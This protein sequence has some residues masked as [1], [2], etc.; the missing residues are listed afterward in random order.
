M[1][2]GMQRV[3]VVGVGRQEE[4]GVAS[5]S[6]A[7]W[8]AIEDAHVVPSA[9]RRVVVLLARTDEE[10][11]PD[12]D[13]IPGVSV[14]SPR[15]SDPVYAAAEACLRAD[16]PALVVV[17]DEPGGVAVALALE[18]AQAEH[19]GPLSDDA[20]E[21]AAQLR[22]LRPRDRTSAPRATSPDATGAG[23]VPLLLSGRTEAGLRAQ[24]GRLATHLQERTDISVADAAFTQ[25]TARTL[26][27]HRAMV[28]A[29]DRVGV[30][31]ALRAVA[32]GRAGD[33]A[34]RAGS[35]GPGSAV[36]V[37]PGQ[38]A[39]WVGM[40]RELAA[41]APVFRDKLAECAREL[42]PFVDF[43]LDD[44][45][46]G[47]L[48]LERV[49]VIQPALFAVMVS[50]AELWRSNGVT[51]AAVVGHSFGE[52][53]AVTA[54]GA[55]TLADG[56][57]LV[58]AV[59][60]ALARLQGNGEMVAVALPAEQV[61]ALV[62]EWDLDLDIAVVNGPGST[63]VAGTTESATT[64]LERLRARDVRA[65][66]LPIG[67]AG[68]SWRMEPAHEYLV[69][70][71]A[72]VRPRATR[73]P[74]Y[75]STTTDPLDT[76]ALDAE[77]WFLSLREPARFQQVIEELLGQGHRVFVEMSPHPVLTL[78]IEETAAHL[79]REVVV[80]DTMR[81]DDAGHDRYLRA[82]AEAHLHGVAPDWSTV[83]PDARRVSLPPYRLDLD[84]ADTAGSDGAGPGSELRERLL[85]C[86]PAQ[87]VDEAVRLVADAVS[88]QIEPSA[89][90]IGADEAFRSLGVD[91]A[92]AL[93]VRNRLVEMT[94]L[95]LPVT[96][97]FDHPTP[98]ALAEELVRALLGGDAPASAP[99]AS[100]PVDPDEP[101]AIV[102]M[103]C[104]FPGG[105]GSPDELWQLVHEGRDAVAAF[106]A[107]RGWDLTA[108][109]DADASQ[110]G[111][112][113]QREAALLDGVAE[114]DAGFFG[115][116]SREALAMDPQQR[117]LLETSW[118]ALE[119]GGID[120]AS[121][122]GS[123]T[124]VFTGVMSLPYGQPLHQAR[125]D[126]EGYVM[127]GTTSS[128]V[129]GRLSY[130]LGLEGPALTL[131]T[132]CSSSLVALHLA[133]QSLRRGESDLALVGG[134]TVM[135][136]PGL[137][138]EFSRLRA[139][140]PD[141]RSKPFSADADGF[142]MAE[143]VAVLVVE[144]LSDARRLGHDVLAVV[145]GSAVNQDGASNGLT[146]PSGPAQQRAI[147]AA[148]DSAGLRA[149]DVDVVEAHGT[150]TRLGDPIEAQALLATYGSDRPA[151]RPLYVGS[152]KSNIG[153]AQA[154]AGVAGVVKMVQALRHGV[155]P[156]SL[157]ADNPAH[158]VEWSSDT[159]E[160]LAQAREWDRADGRPRRAGV[161][162]F[163]ISGT[164]AHIILEE[165]TP[166]TPEASEGAESAAPWA[167]VAVP[168][169]LSGKTPEAVR[170]Q[171][172]ALRE[173]L[174]SHPE[175]PLVHV[176]RELATRRTAF[177]HRA[178]VTGDREEVR[179]GL[180]EVSPVLAGSG[181]VAAVF[182]GQG[183]QRA[184]M[185]RQLAA[186]FPVFDEALA[187]V[188]GHLD[189]ELGRGLREVMWS[190]DPELLGRTEFAQPALFAFEVA[191]ARLW[192]S[193]GVS[194]TAVVGHSVGE[195]AAAVVAGVLTVP[196]AARLVVARGRLMQS[197]PGGG[198]MLAV[199]AGEDEVAAT[200]GD[201]ARVAV[202]AVNGPGAVVV[203]GARDE[204][205]RVGEIWRGRGRRVTELRVSHAFHS[206]L[207]EPVLDEFRA[208]VE[209]LRFRPPTV[210]IRAT[211]DTAHPIDTPEYW[212]DHARRAVRFGDA[213]E[214]LAEADILIEVGPDA[215]LAPLI[216]TG[217]TVL[218][219]TRRGRSET[220][221][222]LTALGR[223]H[224]HGADVDWAA[225]LPPAP[226]T[227][228]PTY[229]FQRQ[230]YWD[231][232]SDAS[233]GAGAGA[234][235]RSHPMLT[236]RTDLP[237]AGGL[238]LSGRLAP[239]SDPWL[240][241]H[242]VMG[243]VLLP[244]TG[245]VELA[246]EA[247]RA[248]GAGSVDELVLRAP[249]VF[250]EGAPRDLQVWVGPDQGAERELQI[251][252]RETGGDWT[253]HATGLLAARTADTAGFGDGDW[254]GEIWP[255]AG[256]R[257]L[258]GRSFYEE[259][260]ARGYEYGP[261][262]HGTKAL[263]ERAGDLFA[264][265]VLP[266]GQPRGFGIHPALLDAALHALPITGSLYEAGEV[267]LP[268]SFNSVS[269]FSS[270]ARRLRVRIRADAD[271]AAVW[272]TDDA[273]SPVLAMEG[274][275]LRSIER[276]QL[277]AAGAT[278][279]TGWFAETW[280]QEGRAATTDRVPGTWLLLGEVPP[281]L[282]SLFADPVTAASWDR[283][284]AP[285][286]VLVGA[287]RAEDLLAALHEVAGRQTGP[288]WCV[289]SGA[290]TV[291]TADPAADVRAAG[292][293]G[294][295]RV[296]GLELP[297]RWGGLVDLP[298]RIDDATRRA[299][300]GIL[301]GDGPDDD[302]A[303]DQ[304]AVRD[305]QLW[306]RRL[307]PASAPQTG[308][309]TPKGTVL[310]TG[311]TGGL[312]G[313]VAR[314][315]AEQGSADRVLLLSRQGPAA[316]GATELLAEISA[317]GTRAEA[318]AVDVTDR[319]AMGDLL[320]ALAAEGAPVRTV[321]HAAGVVRDVRITE[322]GA[323]EL[324][325]QMAAKVEGA[326]L[327]DE[328]LPDLDDFVLFSSISGVWGAAG[329]A[330]YA[331]GNACL[332]AL[333]RRRRGQGRPALSV[334]WG[335][336]AGGG[337]LTEHDERELR[338]RGLTPLLVPAAL[339]AL[340]QGIMADGA[341]DPV[342]ADIT[343]SRFLPAFTASR[344]SP[345][346]GS[347]EE[348]AAALDPLARTDGGH[349]E[350]EAQS[351]TQRLAALPDAERLP[352]LTEV[353]QTHV[354]ALIGESGPER[355]SPDRALKEIGFDSLMSVELRNRFAGLIGVK[356]P[357]T[358]VFD[359]PTPHALAEHLLGHLDLGA[360]GSAPADRP[361]LEV[362]EDLQD[363][364]LSPL[365]DAA[366]RQALT[367][368]LTELLDRLSAL[369]ARPVAGTDGLASAS[370]AELMQFIDTELGDL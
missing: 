157:Y 179:A 288:V 347:F 13:G 24:A 49:E 226:R 126:L 300:A 47:A 256:A 359:H 282:G 21:R 362:V 30:V 122:R 275:I 86:T 88:G 97:L 365:T 174:A 60:K 248:A 197:L 332:D 7:L 323:E 223:A 139:L 234:D 140:A 201:A 120:S 172:L 153:H 170:G 77:H 294:L 76:G 351:L 235:P 250:A 182:S 317:F 267:R 228:L 356:L 39:Q 50:L 10:D 353:V 309:W 2:A 368:R 342:V 62:D 207:M 104:R 210:P 221:T 350:G 18:T 130:V 278:G 59:S 280:R 214:R 161:S 132:A 261:A 295:G 239:G 109:Y 283:S 305:G 57:R 71:A 304:L 320:T 73:I 107:D 84:T 222:V 58:A 333:A 238:L 93:R 102:G 233:A 74:V 208:V 335:P 27:P 237:G 360:A 65:A 63:V 98:R 325:A 230:R 82:L 219:S 259:L 344:P 293:W 291:G 70:E 198:A 346:L 254:A 215:A 321:V 90:A 262:F 301:T 173:H 87:R 26:W 143:G 42:R 196:D 44:V 354:A 229:A 199:A 297:D 306:V 181:R 25:A 363:R 61:T 216:E 189:A 352:A 129:S 272:I 340:E 145:R 100:A 257:Q 206:P 292:V 28:T 48:P 298:E 178:V 124:G 281:A 35:S 322:T 330:G 299:L 232:A 43:E 227:D 137:F 11:L 15:D 12:W 175:L 23:A 155:M 209:K 162:A 52:I 367:G 231:S 99:A 289:T 271:T 236:S 329:Q 324:A 334:A 144:R 315:I 247:A 202:A 190:D 19:Y 83:L 3:V 4:F 242:V 54:A 89:T 269:L 79:G 337:M 85:G 255:P 277:E 1:T 165:F 260:A 312:G 358:L 276:A 212:V 218:A 200:L 184:E 370:A 163:G 268:F 150:G 177:E 311:G 148:L 171:A 152:L 138:I 55:L 302:G 142:G 151:E 164:N 188:C 241:H 154:A 67:I 169:V 204:V 123:R 307:A 6:S 265:V 166:E 68:H 121:L 319:A 203:S 224:A 361:L 160:L 314:R 34:V 33:A 56:A 252:T 158:E 345:L 240:S 331:A 369:D 192:E 38:G 176:A 32:E 253:L 17:C 286:G 95:R 243:T 37:F 194:F 357:A 96:V 78:P 336:W 111:T 136:E 279:R 220:H 119:R 114:F 348:K 318:V 183:A 22:A 266:E 105:V 308:T 270:D 133:G 110:P 341:W 274:L 258:T 5:V 180:G 134:A 9:G 91:S 343:W 186:D 112:S 251:R 81:R 339:Q 72:A 167:D 127:T 249:M 125:P 285:D 80:L 51:P 349:A 225:L 113:Y 128:V 103:A 211:A 115:I 303:E 310:I 245:F 284:T 53:A 290:V 94:G 313:H 327:L 195:I 287:A 185:G 46:S 29:A 141:G 147:R 338:K 159:V 20:E 106:P 364:V 217:H 64:L 328:M 36:F 92:G 45:L 131:D 108:L 117:L 296:A 366:T 273:G 69:R 118:E 193:W 205:A 41:T 246:L 244:G 8:A 263:W 149:A 31:A 146:A 66:L 264:E 326:L 135:A 168:L 75:T 213:I 16:R 116:S 14:R 156:R 187:E 191:L 40:A 101:I 355:V 316:P